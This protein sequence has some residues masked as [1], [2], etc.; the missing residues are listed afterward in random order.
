V[1]RDPDAFAR[2]RRLSI[3]L[4][5]LGPEAVPEVRRA[6]ASPAVDRGAVEI[7]LLVQLWATHD[8][9]SAAHWAFTQAPPGFRA[10]ATLP[11]VETWAGSDPE[12]ALT[13]MRELPVAPGVTTMAAQIALVRGWFDSG[14]PGLEDYIQSLGPSFDRQR[15]LS[16]F[17]RKT[18]QRNGPIALMRWA[19]SLPDEPQRFKLSAFR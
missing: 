8:P 4:P 18:I 1:L 2:A 13:W 14:R 12:A 11:S 17:A 7:V 9:A 5:T 16:V 10:A 6:L 19:E 15:A 3:L